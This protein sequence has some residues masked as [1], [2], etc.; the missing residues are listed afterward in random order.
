M[1]RAKAGGSFCLAG[2][3]KTP[4]AVAAASGAAR[5]DP[6]SLERVLGISVVLRIATGNTGRVWG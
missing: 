4:V 3:Q 1:R 6:R 2:G 5:A